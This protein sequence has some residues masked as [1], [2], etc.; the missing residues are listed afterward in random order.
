MLSTMDATLEYYNNH[1]YTYPWLP[2]DGID[3]DKISEDISSHNIS[4]YGNFYTNTQIAVDIFTSVICFIGMVG[5]GIVVWLLG[6][7]IKK[8][9]FTIY[10]LN[11]A[12]ADF[13]LLFSLIFVIVSEWLIVLH[14]FTT[15]F[16]LVSLFPFLSM[17]SASQFLLTVISIERC[18]A[19]FFPLWHQC[20]QQP[21]L[22]TII[23]VLVWALSFLL[24]AT[25]CSMI[26]INPNESMVDL[27][28]QFIVNAVLCLPLVM[29]STVALFVKV[30]FKVQHHQKGKLLTIILLTLLFFLLLVFPLNIIYILY[31]YNYVPSYV[32][33]F[34]TVL[35][36]INSS[37][38][39][40]IYFLVGRQWKTRHRETMKMIFQRVF[41][42]EEC[43]TEE[44]ETQV[45]LE[46]QT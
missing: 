24:S 33:A 28:Y 43:C 39:P 1:S 38:N 22:S 14:D 42:E 13:G 36:C 21:H 7:C 46:T 15:V 37:V 3:H 31:I 35:S 29:I 8:N 25:T 20:H 12:V 27:F 17:H 30:C 11:L 41:K 6:F 2:N 19:A 32:P 16:S 23:C 45:E 9:H 18:V 5:N 44:L 4:Y 10:I 34:A 26:E 40:V